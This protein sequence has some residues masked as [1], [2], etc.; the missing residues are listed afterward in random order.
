M[1]YIILILLAGLILLF[2]APIY[3]N[4]LFVSNNG[5]K[6]IFLKITSMLVSIAVAAYA[7]LK[8]QNIYTTNILI[9]LIIC[10][11]ADIAICYNFLGGTIL[12]ALGHIFYLCLLLG[13]ELNIKLFVIFF[14]AVASIVLLIVYKLKEQL[15]NLYDPKKKILAIPFILYGLMLITLLSLVYTVT[16]INPNNIHILLSIGISFFVVS[17][18]TLVINLLFPTNKLKERVSISFYYIGQFIIACSALFSYIF[19][20][21]K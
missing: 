7:Y 16:Y 12:F 9:A 19:S 6:T 5:V 15:L 4:Q 10:V 2:F 1:L 17:D 21:A 18:I 8:F 13:L 3:V 11:I 14:I 20:T